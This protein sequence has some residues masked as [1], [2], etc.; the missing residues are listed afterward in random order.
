MEG[1]VKNIV[2]DRGFGFIR[3]DS[4][5]EYFF[6]R[7]GCQPRGMFDTLNERDEV[8]FEVESSEKGPRAGN[9]RKL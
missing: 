5:Q 2:R 4:G 6:H 9:V 3:V 7:S 8:S 1:Y